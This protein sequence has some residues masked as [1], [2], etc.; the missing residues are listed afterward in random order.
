MSE[1]GVKNWIFDANES[2]IK[3][4]PGAFAIEVGCESDDQS[5]NNAFFIMKNILT[6]FNVIAE[7]SNSTSTS[8]NIYLIYHFIAVSRL[9]SLD[10]KI[11]DF[12]YVKKGQLIGFL[13]NKKPLLAR[14]GFYPVLINDKTSIKKAKRIIIEE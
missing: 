1:S 2:F 8:S 7:K 14:E 6:Y 4:A 5:P 3:F 10:N 13:K 12:R 9:A 11:K